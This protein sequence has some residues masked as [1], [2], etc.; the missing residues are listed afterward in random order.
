MFCSLDEAVA[1]FR[2]GQFLELVDAVERED[3]GDMLVAADHII[4][5]KI[6]RMRTDAR[7]MLHVATT[8]DHLAR[9]RI[10]PR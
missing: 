2:V 1:D 5:A 4:G 3:E 7:G 8:E 10:G 6:N 9:L